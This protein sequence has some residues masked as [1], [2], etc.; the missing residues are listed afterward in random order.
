MW[1]K[2][3]RGTLPSELGSA[4]RN[5]RGE[6]NSGAMKTFGLTNCLTSRWKKEVRLLLGQ[7][8]TTR[9][10]VRDFMLA[11]RSSLV[12]PGKMANFSDCGKHCSDPYCKQKAPPLLLCL[13]ASRTCCPSSAMDVVRSS[14]LNTSSTRRINV[15]LAATR[16]AIR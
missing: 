9:L 13:N 16:R 1:R 5:A 7:V 2:A 3:L 12:A 11:G 4:S 14:V 8:W 6:R 15:R 10:H